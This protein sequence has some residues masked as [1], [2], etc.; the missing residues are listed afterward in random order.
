MHVFD[1]K[2]WYNLYMIKYILHGGETGVP[3]EHNKAFYQTWLQGF[4]TNFV[5]TILLVY[6]ARPVEEWAKLKNQDEER[7]GKY[8]NY[9]QANMIVASTNLEE[10]TKQLHEANVVDV[11]GGDTSNLMSKMSAIK[12]RLLEIIDNKI[13]IG[14]SAGVM[15]L[16]HFMRS[17]TSGWKE[18]FGLLPI[19][20]FVHYSKEWDEDLNIFRNDHLE[21]KLEYLLIPETE[22][23]VRE[24]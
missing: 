6:F 8:T 4:E 22:F 18:G 13:Y 23:V 24:Y 14:S 9:Q 11:R 21:N 15:I 10:F 20:C 7:L 3:N 19:N 1:V 12:D 16:S 2:M 5:P 17:N